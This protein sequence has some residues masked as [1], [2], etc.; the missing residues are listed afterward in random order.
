MRT[1]TQILEAI[2]DDLHAADQRLRELKRELA[3]MKRL[4]NKLVARDRAIA[5]L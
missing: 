4:A 5:Q 3:A 2:D 1:N